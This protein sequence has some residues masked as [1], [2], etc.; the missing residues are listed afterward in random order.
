MVEKWLPKLRPALESLCAAWGVPL[1][2]AVGWIEAESGGRIDEVTSL[3]ERGYFQLLPE[4]SSDLGLQHVRLTSD[5]AYS[6]SAGFKLMT[7]YQRAVVRI[8]TGAGCDYVRAGSEYQWRLVK[9]AHSM[10]QGALKVIFADAVKSNSV[11][12]WD[13]L[14]SFAV[15]HETDYVSRLRHSPTKW[16][17]LVDRVFTTGAPFGVEHLLAPTPAGTPNV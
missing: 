8:V 16:F 1:G 14:R 6:L 4:E 13:M 2:V 9:L 10:G 7:Y 5:S 11:V 15:Q 12:S 3:G 17:A